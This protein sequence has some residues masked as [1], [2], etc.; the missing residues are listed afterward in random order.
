MARGTEMAAPVSFSVLILIMVSLGMGRGLS[1]GYTGSG[2]RPWPKVVAEGRTFRP[3]NGLR[4]RTHSKGD[5]DANVQSRPRILLRHRFAHQDNVPVH[6]R[7]RRP[8]RL[9]PR[10]TY[11][12]RAFLE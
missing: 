5:H 12:A 1:Q 6:P 10:S 7:P 4:P 9:A 3:R 8:D 2:P 11:R